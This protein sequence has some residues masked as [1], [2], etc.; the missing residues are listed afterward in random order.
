MAPST[1][2]KPGKEKKT[3]DGTTHKDPWNTVLFNCNCHTFDQVA[4]QLMKAVRVSYDQGMALANV[5]HTQG[6]AVV[7]TGHRERCEAV[8]MVLEDIKLIVKVCQ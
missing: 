6:K 7:Y 4:R 5:V 2:K 1:L 3:T 8:A